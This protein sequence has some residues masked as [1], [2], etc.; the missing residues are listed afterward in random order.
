[1]ADKVILRTAKWELARGM[2]PEP[3]QWKVWQLMSGVPLILCDEMGA[4][5][6]ASHFEAAVEG[7]VS[8]LASGERLRLEVVA[9]VASLREVPVVVTIDVTDSCFPGSI[10]LQQVELSGATGTAIVGEERATVGGSSNLNHPPTI[11][12]PF[13]RMGQQFM[14]DL[15]SWLGRTS[16]LWIDRWASFK[17]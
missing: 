9:W 15:L 2:F 6:I 1:M 16:H 13:F 11:S 5:F 17:L 7:L 3:Q 4:S 14:F 8:I 12:P 10:D